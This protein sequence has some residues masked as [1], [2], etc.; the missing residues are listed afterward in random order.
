VRVALFEDDDFK[1]DAIV[2]ELAKHGV[3]D[4]N[5]L[6]LSSLAEFAAL[7]DKTIDLYIV[8]LLMPSVEGGE[9]GPVGI[10]ILSM[11]SHAG[12]R[13]SPVLAITAYPEVAAKLRDRFAANGCLIFQYDDTASWKNALSQFIMQARERGR[14]DFILVTALDE[15]RAPLAALPGIDLRSEARNGLDVWEFQI[16]GYP[17]AAILLQRMGLVNC[18]VTVAQILEHYSPRVIA[19]TGICAGIRKDVA[20]GQVLIADPCWEYQSGKWLSEVFEAEPYQ[21]TIPQQTRIHLTKLIEKKGLL[22]DVEADFHGTRPS[23]PEPPRLAAFATG[24]AVIAS[25]ERLNGILKQHRKVSGVDM[26][27]YGFYRAVEL[28]GKTVHAFCAKAVVDKADENKGDLYHPYGAHVALR[29][30]V[31]AIKELLE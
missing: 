12:R 25:K 24:S 10:E 31:H 30:C 6:I 26:E 18:A 28:S 22:V 7:K 4:S 23:N 2:A 16:D 11:L 27:A 1:R 20:M 14:Y 15:E 21:A 17:G 5:V 13:D 8:D 9:V 3:R 29:F 19:M